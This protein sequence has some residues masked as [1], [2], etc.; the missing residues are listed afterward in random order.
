MWKNR[1]YMNTFDEQLLCIDAQTG[2]ML[3]QIQIDDPA[4]K[5]FGRVAP[6]V[7][8]DHLIVGTSGDTADLPGFLLSV[9]PVDGKIEWRWDA[10][11]K[12]GDRRRGIAG[13]TRVRT[14]SLAAAG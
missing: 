6:L 7:I 14:S 4:L 5:A 3:W 12:P 11:P 8:G 1:L 10:M 2:K 13:R 9:D